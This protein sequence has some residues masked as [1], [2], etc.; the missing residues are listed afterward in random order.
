MLR[1][2]GF[3]RGKSDSNR[4]GD[5]FKGCWP[6]YWPIP[7]WSFRQVEVHGLL[8]RT[9]AGGGRTLYLFLAEVLYQLSYITVNDRP[10]GVMLEHAR[11]VERPGFEPGL[12]VLQTDVQ[13]GYTISR[14]WMS[15]RESNPQW[16]L[17]KKLCCRYTTRQWL[18]RSFP[19]HRMVAASRV[20]LEGTSL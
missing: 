17:T 14:A 3:W 6:T 8:E 7:R 1:L 11:V 12:S 10:E 5:S 2:R 20:E 4:H 9:R 15:G 13:T 19:S 18:R 16:L